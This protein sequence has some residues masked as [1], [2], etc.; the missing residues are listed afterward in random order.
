MNYKE[1]IPSKE[2]RLK[3]LRLTDFLPDKLMIK[4][5]YKIATGRKLNLKNPQRFTEKLQWYKLYHRDPLM[6]RCADKYSVRGYVTSKGYEEILVPLYGVYD[7]VNEIDFEKLPN[8]F[9]LK[10]TNGSQTNLICNNKLELNIEETKKNIDKWLNIWK[11][12]IGR[13]WAYYDIKPKVICEKLLEKDEDNDIV[14]YKFFC[15][16]GKVEYL[17]VCKERFSESGL[18]MGFYD[19]NFNF[20]DINRDRYCMADNYGQKLP[21]KQPKEFSKMLHIAEQ[22]SKDFPH[23]RV[24][25]YNIRGKVYF[26]ELT[27]YDG[28]GYE[29]YGSFDVILGE[30]YDIK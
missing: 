7:N 27:F 6:T 5:Q 9:V 25:L 22:L 26:G 16:N 13:E 20:I 8:E 23:V 1:L 15:F 11:G 14:D 24:D 10:T 19:R 2:L 28:S 17:N 12:K 29:D 3:I 18:K 30:K 4:L 21:V